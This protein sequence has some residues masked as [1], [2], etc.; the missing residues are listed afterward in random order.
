M[1]AKPT[2]TTEETRQGPFSLLVS[3]V[4][5]GGAFGSYYL[6]DGISNPP[7]ASATLSF[8]AS[9]NQLQIRADGEFNIGQPLEEITI[10]GVSEHPS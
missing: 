8:V 6:D 2:Y 7:G 5:N 1:H 3:L 4:S 9:D 10:L